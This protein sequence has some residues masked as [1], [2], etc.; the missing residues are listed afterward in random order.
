M[1][2]IGIDV[3]GTKIAGALVDAEGN[4][5][6]EMRVATPSGDP[7]AVVDATAQI[8]NERSDGQQVVGAGVAVPAFIDA[9]QSEIY[10]GT[11]LAYRN[12]PFKAEIEAKVSV[13]VL[14][15]NDANAAGWAEYRYGAGKGTKHMVMLTIGTGVGGAIVVDSHLLRGGFGVAAEL[16]HMRVVPEGR[17]CA[18]GQYGCIEQYASGTA[19]LRGAKELAASGRPEGKRLAEIQHETGELTGLQVAQAIQENDPGAVALIQEVGSWIGQTIGSLSAVLDPEIVVIGGG[20]SA[21]GDVLMDPI[22]KA[23][24]SHMPARG[25]RPELQIKAAEFLNDAGL[26]GAADLARRAFGKL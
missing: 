22:R 6:R 14:L 19:L 9:N 7:Q 13:P 12:G 15:E 23:F 18:C 24:Q 8:I 16:G 20:V 10:Y 2:A 21:L 3:G 26:V 17:L 4:L 1:H 25:F 11:N 5:L